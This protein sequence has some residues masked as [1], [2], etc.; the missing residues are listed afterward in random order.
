MGSIKSFGVQSNLSFH[1]KASF[2][3]M[4]PIEIDNKVKDEIELAKTFNSHYKASNDVRNF[5]KDSERKRNCYSYHSKII[6][7]F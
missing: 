2:I 7:A 1:Q 4:T 6:E 5:S 3:M